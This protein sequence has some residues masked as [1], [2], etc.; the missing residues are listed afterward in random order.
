MGKESKMSTER[1]T[2]SFSQWFHKNARE[3]NRKVFYVQAGSCI[4]VTFLNIFDDTQCFHQTAPLRESRVT[5][6]EGPQK[7]GALYFYK[8]A[9]RI[10]PGIVF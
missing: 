3:N 1:R 6:R 5:F 4:V 8:A 9:C 7:N 10:N 2:F